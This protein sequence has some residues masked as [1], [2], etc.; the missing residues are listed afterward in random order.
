MPIQDAV[1]PVNGLTVPGESV[2]GVLENHGFSRIRP[3]IANHG[4]ELWLIQA[5][6]NGKRKFFIWSYI[7]DCLQLVK[8]CLALEALVGVVGLDLQ[9][10]DVV[11]VEYPDS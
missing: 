10:L 4:Q 8:G 11:Y 3:I 7:R 6:K 1:V 9:A 2:H 5:E